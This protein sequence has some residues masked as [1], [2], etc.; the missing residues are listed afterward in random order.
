[1][2]DKPYNSFRTGLLDL[3]K[4]PPYPIALSHQYET[5]LPSA[6]RGT[7]RR[8]QDFIPR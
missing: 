4:I 3:L 6:R 7:L 5:L 1:M 2:G 8:L